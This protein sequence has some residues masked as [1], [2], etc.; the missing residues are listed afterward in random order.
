MGYLTTRHI[1]LFLCPWTLWI[2]YKGDKRQRDVET[3]WPWAIVWWG[4]LACE[5]NNISVMKSSVATFSV[6]YHASRYYWRSPS[7]HC[8][9]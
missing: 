5:K 2:S 3:L 1:P 4:H 7:C 6:L 8:F 9:M